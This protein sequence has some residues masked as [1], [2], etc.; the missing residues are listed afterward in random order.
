MRAKAS[1]SKIKIFATVLYVVAA[2][3]LFAQQNQTDHSHSAFPHPINA[4]MA[5][6]DPVGSYNVRLNTF[7]QQ[8]ETK[9]EYDVSGH[10]SYGL[11]DWGGIHLRSLGVR[12]TPFTEIIGMVGLWRNKERT[13]GISLLGI[14][15]VPTGRKSE[16][17]KEHGLAYLFGVTG[18]IAKKDL[19]TNDILLHY[20]F[21]AGHFIAETGSVLKLSH[22]LFATLDTRGIFGGKIKPDISFMPA[23]KLKFIEYGFIAL[24]YNTATTN[25]T[26]FK[27]Q[28][29]LQFEFGNH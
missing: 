24:G 12:T 16:E 10:I 5:I 3:P 8:T 11:F 13:E 22:S 19:I 9:T 27:N 7:R 21:S 18:R 15:G 29:F 6:P 1:L 23:L 25:G 26:L 14:V 2:F 17:G 28:V 20:D 4:T